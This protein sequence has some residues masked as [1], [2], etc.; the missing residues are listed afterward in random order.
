MHKNFVFL[1]LAAIAL[2]ACDSEIAY[3]EYQSLKGD[4]EKDQSVAFNFVAPDTI[5]PYNI[6]INL[7][8]NEDYPFSNLFLI[9]N[10]DFPE[11][12]TISDTLEYEMAKPNGE[13]LGKGF[14]SVK[15][16]KLFYKEAVVFPDTGSYKI[17]IEHAMRKNSNV[18][19]VKSL[20]GITDVGIS[21]EKTAK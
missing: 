16:N 18:E 13:W 2:S 6:Y 17:A 10:L 12:K 9:V 7:R 3:G 21:I 4:W 1:C 14:S 19:G 8:N 5:N 11:G 20:K 15:E